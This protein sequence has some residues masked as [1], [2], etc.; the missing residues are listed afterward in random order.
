VREERVSEINHIADHINISLT[1]L[2]QKVDEEIGKAAAEVEKKVTGAEGRLAQAENRHSELMARREKRRQELGKSLWGQVF[3]FAVLLCG[4]NSGD[5][6]QQLT[7]SMRQMRTSIEKGSFQPFNRSATF[8]TGISPF[9][10]FQSFNRFAQ[11][12]T[13]S[14]I[15]VTWKGSK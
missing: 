14:R 2:I 8:T 5:S 7:S 15:L 10:A 6:I 11:F 3:T 13:F 12:K 1:E 9:Q 4:S